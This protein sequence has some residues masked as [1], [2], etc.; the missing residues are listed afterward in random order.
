[1]A[2]KSDTIDLGGL[3]LVVNEI[4]TGATKPN[5]TPSDDQTIAGDLTVAGDLVIGETTLTEEDL[6]ALL[7]TL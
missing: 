2:N 5:Q 4:K 1:M 6:I 7:A 3:T